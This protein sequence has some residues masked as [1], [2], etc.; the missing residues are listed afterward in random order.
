MDI[1]GSKN[2][3]IEF[4]T[5]QL[6]LKLKEWRSVWTSHQ[7]GLI[8]PQPQTHKRYLCIYQIGGVRLDLSA[9]HHRHGHTYYVTFERGIG[10]K[11]GN[12]YGVRPI[13]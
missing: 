13:I 9:L 6:S 1:Q 5:F 3:V 8:S 7:S 11:T 12:L 10:H 2:I 4:Y